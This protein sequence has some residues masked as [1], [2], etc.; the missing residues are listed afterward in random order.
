MPVQTNNVSDLA[1]GTSSVIQ[2]GSPGQQVVMYEVVTQNGQTTQIPIQTIVTVP[3]VT[4]I[5]DE[6]DSLSGIQGGHV[7]SWHITI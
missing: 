3:P 7:S 5:V 4:Q 2:Q 1:Y 6:G